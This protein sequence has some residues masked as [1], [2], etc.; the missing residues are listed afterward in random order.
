[1]NR[2]IPEAQAKAWRFIL[3]P[4]GGSAI[5]AEF[6]GSDPKVLRRLTNQAKAIMIADGGALSIK[7]NWRQPVSVIEPIYSETKGRR[8]G[9][10]RKDLADAILKFY[11]GKQVG[12]YREDE[13]LI[14]I[15]S[16]LPNTENAT[17]NDIKKYSGAECINWKN[18]PYCTSD[19]WF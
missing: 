1:M 4:G 5:E 9:I 3:G 18:D 13:D 8:A 10:S 19:P 2:L 12:V 16:R 6:S 14:P 15:I 11:S 7:D 17:I